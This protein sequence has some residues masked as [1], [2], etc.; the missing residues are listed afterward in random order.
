MDNQLLDWFLTKHPKYSLGNEPN[1]LSQYYLEQLRTKILVPIA[2]EFGHVKI[3]YGFTNHSLLRHI[4]NHS[5]GNMA[6]NIDQH[7]SMECNSKGTRICKRDGAACD[8]YVEGY[9]RE[10]NEIAKFICKNLEFDRLYFYGKENPLHIS[11]GPDNSRFALIRTTRNDGLRVNTKS[12]KGKAT[13]T[14]FEHL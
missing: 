5:S 14:L 12:A 4:L 9:K 8:F 7:A 13:Q 1:E 3:T 2:S 10:M 11:V 6:P